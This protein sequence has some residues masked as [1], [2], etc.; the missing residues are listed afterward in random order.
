MM[1]S[2]LCTTTKSRDFINKIPGFL[3]FITYVSYSAFSAQIRI[4]KINCRTLHSMPHQI[5]FTSITLRIYDYAA[6]IG[7][8]RI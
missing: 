8:K 4:A 1:N 7:I 2:T 3:Y 5:H 6:V